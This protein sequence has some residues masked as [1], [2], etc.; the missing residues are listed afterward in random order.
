MIKIKTKYIYNTFYLIIVLQ[1]IRIALKNIFALYI[2]EGSLY[3]I[4]FD[5]LFLI[6]GIFIIKNNINL[7]DKIYFNK[8]SNLLL[9]LIIIFGS[10]FLILNK[11]LTFDNIINLIYISLVIPTFEEMLFKGYFW[12]KGKNIF[13][14]ERVLLIVL[15]IAFVLWNA[16]Y[17]DYYLNDGFNLDKFNY[18][19]FLLCSLG[20]GTITGLIRL[21][22]KNL[23]DITLIRSICNI[24]ARWI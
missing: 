9:I 15:T 12:E 20:I 13:K 19:K 23:T 4:A 10:L 11:S 14:N 17:I 24:L 5:A 22:S 1:L 2:P 21:R 18:F 7:K 3:N 6:G 16:G 8:Y